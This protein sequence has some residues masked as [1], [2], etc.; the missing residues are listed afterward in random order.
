MLKL[1]RL[2]ILIY[3]QKMK[4]INEYPLL[5]YSWQTFNF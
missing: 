2:E 4:K 5:R 1:N 3:S